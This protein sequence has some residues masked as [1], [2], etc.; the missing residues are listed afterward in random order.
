MKSAKKFLQYFQGNYFIMKHSKVL[1][2]KDYN[3]S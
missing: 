3:L 2:K 1:Y